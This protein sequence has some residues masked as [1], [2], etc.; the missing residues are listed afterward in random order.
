ML[1]RKTVNL[2]QEFSIPLI[3]GVVVALIVANSNGALYDTL[4]HTPFTQWNTAFSAAGDHDN[5]V[6]HGVV[7]VEHVRTAHAEALLHTDARHAVDGGPWRPCL[8]QT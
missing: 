3:A 8:W 2:L 7:A 5:D 6:G 1:M 4:I